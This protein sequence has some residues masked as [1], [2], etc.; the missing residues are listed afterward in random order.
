MRLLSVL[1]LAAAITI[2]CQENKTTVQEPVKSVAETSKTLTKEEHLAEFER[3]SRGVEKILL[4][5]GDNNRKAK[6]ILKYVKESRLEQIEKKKTLI[7]LMNKV[8]LSI[9]DQK[10][11]VYLI[12]KHLSK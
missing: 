5:D 3:Y 4:L 12:D 6:M 7:K 10:E 2:S 9:E 11:I 8:K 1:G